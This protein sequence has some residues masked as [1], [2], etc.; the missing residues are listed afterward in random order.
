MEW[1]RCS[2]Q[3][4]CVFSNL[5]KK[6]GWRG[7]S[8]LNT[9]ELRFL[10]PPMTP[11]FAANRGTSAPV[12]P[13]FSPEKQGKNRNR[14]DLSAA[15]ILPIKYLHPRT[16]APRTP[17]QGKFDDGPTPEPGRH[18]VSKNP[19]G[20]SGRLSCCGYDAIGKGGPRRGHFPPATY[21]ANLVP[22]WQLKQGRSSRARGP[23][24]GN[25]S[26]ADVT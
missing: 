22:E 25:F 12:S 16:D 13:L 21:S 15:N 24:R 7:N 14:A 8:A 11:T 17:Q 3:P 1:S 18:G 2:I 19:Q 23:S 10:V 9:G 5:R 20:G 26:L 6:D 4:F